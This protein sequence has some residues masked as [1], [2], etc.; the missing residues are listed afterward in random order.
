MQRWLPNAPQM[1]PEAAKLILKWSSWWSC[2]PILALLA[3][4]M[5]S[6][7]FKKPSFSLCFTKVFVIAHFLQRSRPRNQ[8]TH[9][10]A[11]RRHQVAHLRAILTPT[12]ASKSHL[13]PTLGPFLAPFSHLWD[14]LNIIFKLKS[15]LF[16]KVAKNIVK[17]MQNEPQHKP[18]KA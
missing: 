2:W 4:K 8:K 13:G 15:F 11:P 10:D 9:Q 7:H 18:V 1:D 6:Q 12:W 17:T 3:A 5:S 16:E 14:H